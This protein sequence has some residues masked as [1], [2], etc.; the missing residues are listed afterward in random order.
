MCGVQMEAKEEK[1]NKQQIKNVKYM[2]RDIFPPPRS[3][4]PLIEHSQRR[5]GEQLVAGKAAVGH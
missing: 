5:L 1:D 4:T 2:R 3:A